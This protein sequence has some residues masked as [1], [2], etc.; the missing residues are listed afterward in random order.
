MAQLIHKFPTDCII[1]ILKYLEEDNNTL[2]SCLLVNRLL[3][4]NSVQILWRNVQ[5][6]GTLIACLPN[7]SK[8]ILN[9]NRIIIPTP[10]SK[11]P[12]FNYGIRDLLD[13]FLLMKSMTKLKK[14]LKVINPIIHKT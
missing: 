12:L 5:N 2:R 13:T 7:E 8:E 4:K 14:F 1:E 9:K 10:S 3:C 6:Y 11:P